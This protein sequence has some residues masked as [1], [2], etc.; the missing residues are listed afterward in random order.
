MNPDV[1]AAWCAFTDRF[2]GN[3]PFMYTDKVGLVT[4][5]RGNLIDGG[6]RREK[7]GDYEGALEYNAAMVLPWK[8]TGVRASALAIMQEWFHVK[9]AWPHIQSVSCAAITE[10]RLDPADV[11]ALTLKTLDNMWASALKYFPAAETWVSPAQMGALSM[12]WAMGGAFEAGYPKFDAAA[13]AQDWHVCALECLIN[14]PPVPIARNAMNVKLF[15]AAAA[16]ASLAEV[17]A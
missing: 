4:T 12:A 8:K 6:L 16:G 15:Q 9:G 3:C 14:K 5:G 2:E 11:D 17:L 13:N 10:L 1:R 7:A